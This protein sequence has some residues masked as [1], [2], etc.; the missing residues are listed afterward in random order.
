MLVEMKIMEKVVIP[1]RAEGYNISWNLNLFS[2]AKWTIVC[3]QCEH[4]FQARLPL[5]N[6]PTV[7]C[8]RCNTVNKLPL[9]FDYLNET[10]CWETT[11]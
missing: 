11:E 9:V 4:T 5:V 3:G 2:G 7:T 10:S 8:P 1:K 6:Y